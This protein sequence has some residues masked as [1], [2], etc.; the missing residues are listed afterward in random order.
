MAHR[1]QDLDH[2]EVAP[3]G[4]DLLDALGQSLLHGVHRG[5]EREPARDVLLRRP[6]HLGVD[7]PVRHAG[8]RVLAGH[9]AQ[10]VRGLHHGHRVLEGLQV[11]HQAAGVRAVTEPPAQGLGV[12]GGQLVARL[13]GEV[14]DRGR[15]HSPVQVVVQ[16][17]P[18][19]W[20]EGPARSADG[21]LGG[22]SCA[23]AQ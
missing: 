3:G 23:H 6:P 2:R 14:E 12:G 17:D 11:A 7:E 19:T 4:A 22:L 15:A 1:A 16:A 21:A 20:P 10:G 13:A 8:L 5:V 18:G 9:A